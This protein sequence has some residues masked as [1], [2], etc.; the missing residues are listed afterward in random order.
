MGLVFF[1]SDA[2]DMFGEPNTLTYGPE[3]QS[4]LDHIQSGGSANCIRLRD[5]DFI[6]KNLYKKEIGLGLDVIDNPASDKPMIKLVGDR[7]P[8][9]T[10][11]SST[12]DDTNSYNG[13]PFIMK[14]LNPSLAPSGKLSDYVVDS[15]KFKIQLTAPHINRKTGDTSAYVDN[16][17]R[18]I[19][20][21]RITKSD[22]I[23]DYN[24]TTSGSGARGGYIYV[25]EINNDTYGIESNFK[26]FNSNISFT[27][28]AGNYDEKDVLNIKGGYVHHKI[29][30]IDP[31]G[32]QAR[33][34][35]IVALKK[36]N[37]NT[38]NNIIINGYAI[39]GD[40][41]SSI[42]SDVSNIFMT[43]TSSFGY[44]VNGTEH[45]FT[46][47]NDDDILWIAIPS[48]YAQNMT[49]TD[50]SVILTPGL[51]TS[52]VYINGFG[53]L[54]SILHKLNNDDRLQNC[55]ITH[56]MYH[57][58]WGGLLF[59][60]TRNQA[61]YFDYGD[62]AVPVPGKANIYYHVYEQLKTD[63]TSQPNNI[64]NDIGAIVCIQDKP[65]WIE[66]YQPAQSYGVNY[67]CLFGQYGT[68]GLISADGLSVT[69]YGDPLINGF[70]ENVDDWNKVSA[71]SFVKRIYITFP[72]FVYI[73]DEYHLH[74]ISTNASTDTK[75]GVKYYGDMIPNKYAII[76]TYPDINIPLDDGNE[77]WVV[78]LS[79]NGQPHDINQYMVVCVEK[80]PLVSN[81]LM[82]VDFPDIFH[83]EPPVVTYVTLNKL[84]NV[85]FDNLD[86]HDAFAEDAISIDLDYTVLMLNLK[87][88]LK[89]VI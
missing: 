64:I 34:V 84:F 38:T 14:A 82:R 10:T 62:D 15:R 51:S 78:E 72:G 83:H 71:F 65:Q 4:M 77:D 75:V 49:T 67:Q 37:K 9:L 35:T 1:F 86:T 89:E 45:H 57:I 73:D 50:N 29:H 8:V 2:I 27:A 54:V 18:Y 42:P 66:K 5:P 61:V 39:I 20:R 6:N 30:I 46:L 41:T 12:D 7:D 22:W 52:G 69:T 80:K 23:L 31:K 58:R 3:Y 85:S 79:S 60:T 70:L 55:S 17:T 68:F 28:N 48:A 33:G 44:Q 13:F 11:D 74:K 47:T 40:D 43:D 63:I 25:D 19:V 21:T 53:G 24:A 59:H 87:M 56:T 16:F 26:N 81:S 76:A 88:G 32:S 36:Y